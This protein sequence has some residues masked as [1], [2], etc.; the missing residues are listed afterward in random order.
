M[1]PDTVENIVVGLGSGVGVLATAVATVL[2]ALKLRK[3]SIFT[4]NLGKVPN[5]VA[6]GDTKRIRQLVTKQELNDQCDSRYGLIVR[7]QDDIIRRLDKGDEVFDKIEK[8]IDDHI[9]EIHS[10]SDKMNAIHLEMVRAISENTKSIAVH[11]TLITQMG[12][13][14]R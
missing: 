13:K 11:E 3:M 5:K 9:V 10:M 8:K 2:G 12:S 1:S 14:I 6:D 4:I 7:G